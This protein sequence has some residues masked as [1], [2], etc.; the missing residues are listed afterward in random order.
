[1]VSHWAP[2]LPAGSSIL[3]HLQMKLKPGCCH[4]LCPAPSAAPPYPP[5]GLVPFVWI[6]RAGSWIICKTPFARRKVG[7]GA[8]SWRES[9]CTEVAGLG[10][11]ADY[12]GRAWLCVCPPCRAKDTGLDCGPGLHPAALTQRKGQKHSSMN[13]CGCESFPFF[14]WGVTLPSPDRWWLRLVFHL[15]VLPLLF[16]GSFSYSY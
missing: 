5:G 13:L 4:L 9:C 1:M 16:S 3:T 10:S 2:D 8:L 7:N 6:P 12:P 11:A 15:M 14:M